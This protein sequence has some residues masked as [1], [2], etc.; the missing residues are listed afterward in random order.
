MN[1]IIIKG[2]IAHTPEYRTTQSGTAVCRF[3]VAVDRR[4]KQNG[5]KT[6]DFFDC[7]AWRNS[8]DF[9]SK[10]FAKGQEILIV[11]EMQSRQYEAKDGSK[12]RAWEIN[13]ENAEFCGSKK[14]T[15]TNGAES[16]PQGDFMEIELSGDLPF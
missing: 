2:R 13:V 10:Y 12:R 3:P 14:E 4:F 16:T 7:V 15:G 9:I 6:T 5:E 1:Q 8:A 11:G